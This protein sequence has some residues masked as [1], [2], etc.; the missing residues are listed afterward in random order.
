MENLSTIYHLLL[1][2]ILELLSAGTL[3]GGI[4]WCT[5]LCSLNRCPA[6]TVVMRLVLSL[7]TKSRVSGR[8]RCCLESRDHGTPSPP[9]E[10]RM[11]P[12]SSSSP[13]F[14][15]LKHLFTSRAPGPGFRAENGA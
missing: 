13:H 2:L 8:S 14:I 1:P 15:T 11:K 3:N 6:G 4:M 10:E 7:I 12:N 9:Y 5:I